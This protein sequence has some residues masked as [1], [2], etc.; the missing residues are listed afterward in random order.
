[1]TI[2]PANGRR[3]GTVLTCSASSYPAATYQWIDHTQNDAIVSTDSTYELPLGKY[4]YNLTCV[5]NVTMRCLQGRQV[6]Q[7]PDS[8]WDRHG[9]NADFPFVLFNRATP[10]YNSRWCAANASKSG[11][12]DGK[13]IVDCYCVIITHAAGK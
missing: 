2:N 4:T 3:P 9:Q 8:Y 10:R 11:L 7:D 12:A 13:L 5:A 1:V 6:C